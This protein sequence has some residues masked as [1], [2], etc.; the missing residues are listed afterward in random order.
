MSK[1]RTKNTEVKA[2]TPVAAEPSAED[3]MPEETPVLVRESERSS[4][5]MLRKRGSRG[6]ARRQITPEEEQSESSSESESDEEIEA[7]EIRKKKGA[8][9]GS[10]E[11]QRKSRSYTPRE[12]EMWRMMCKMQKS[13]YKMKLALPQERRGSIRTDEP[14][15]APP[16]AAPVQAPRD[17][18][19]EAIKK[20]ML[21]RL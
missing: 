20:H 19:L 8:K 18:D 1:P 3:S 16:G 2:K 11:P 10:R 4:E 5:Q 15:I 7:I 13:L 21:I 17:S 9:G 12:E 14:S 6:L